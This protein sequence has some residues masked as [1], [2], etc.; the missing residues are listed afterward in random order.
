M[1]K[2]YPPN[3]SPGMAKKENPRMDISLWEPWGKPHRRAP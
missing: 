1:R 3:I 2:K